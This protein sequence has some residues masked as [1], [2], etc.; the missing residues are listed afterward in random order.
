[1]QKFAASP[2]GAVPCAAELQINNLPEWSSCAAWVDDKDGGHHLEPAYKPDMADLIDGPEESAVTND[3]A[4]SAMAKVMNGVLHFCFE[5]GNGEPV[6]LPRAFR[7]FCMVTWALR[8]ELF[9]HMSL[10]A[11][12]PHLHVTK[13]SLSAI[14]RRFCDEHGVRNVL[15]KT[16]SARESYSKAQTASHARRKKRRPGACEAPGLNDDLKNET[17]NPESLE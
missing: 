12:A 6:N 8:P 10:S 17:L 2:I 16:E 9:D 11:L 7:R 5:N 14:V 4:I 15:M 13:A 3:E 1:M